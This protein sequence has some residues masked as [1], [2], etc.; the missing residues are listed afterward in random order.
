MDQLNTLVHTYCIAEQ[1]H[2]VCQ[3]PQPFHSLPKKASQINR[4]EFLSIF[5]EIC[6]QQLTKDAILSIQTSKIDTFLLSMTQ[7]SV[8]CH[9]RYFFEFPIGLHDE[10]DTNDVE[11]Q[12]DFLKRIASA[13]NAVATQSRTK[14][15][16]I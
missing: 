4:T 16:K 1:K 12:F 14:A 5:I 2:C 3:E 7:Y 11:D 13:V 8:H 6:D 15:Y 9:N 10:V